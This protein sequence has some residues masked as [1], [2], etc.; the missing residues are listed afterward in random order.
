MGG[1]GKEYTSDKTSWTKQVSS[2][3]SAKRVRKLK[4]VPLRRVKHSLAL[5]SHLRDGL[6]SD[7]KFE[8]QTQQCRIPATK[9]REQPGTRIARCAMP[10]PSGATRRGKKAACLGGANQSISSKCFQNI[11][12][13]PM[14]YTYHGPG[15]PN[16][17]KIKILCNIARSADTSKAAAVS[18]ASTLGGEG[19]RGCRACRV[20]WRGCISFGQYSQQY[21]PYER[22]VQPL[23]TTQLGVHRGL[24][25]MRA[26]F[27]WQ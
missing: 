24:C 12:R 8:S 7:N 11:G 18:L 9:R 6:L 21:V 26:P 3:W 17:P 19:S 20:D 15:R 25:R 10:D 5:R 2:A 1:A 14:L 16:F 13:H 22:T 27:I 4:Q 23:G